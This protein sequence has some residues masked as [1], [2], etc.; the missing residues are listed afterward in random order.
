MLTNIRWYTV[1]EYCNFIN[2]LL[3]AADTCELTLDI[4]A[5]FDKPA[6]C[7]K[8]D[9]RGSRDITDCSL[10][11]PKI[12]VLVYGFS[13]VVMV[14]FSLSRSLYVAFPVR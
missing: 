11:S 14:Y 12:I 2:S 7:D 6:I 1:Y 5:D 8:Q 13:T 9:V 3:P 10:N 4:T